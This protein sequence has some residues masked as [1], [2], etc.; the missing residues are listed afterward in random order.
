MTSLRESRRSGAASCVSLSMLCLVGLLGA[1]ACTRAPPAPWRPA[2]AQ[3]WQQLRQELTEQRLARPQQPWS[4]GLRI[5][6]RDPTSGRVI[7]GRGAIAVAPGSAVRMILTG[8]AGATMLDAWVTRVRWRVAV[9]PLSLVRRGDL[10]E[11]REMPVGFLRWWFLT[12]L[13]G[14]LFA[15]TFTDG[16]LLW[17]IRYGGAVID[18]REAA[19]AH[20]RLLHATRRIAGHVE[21][22]EECRAHAAPSVGDS[23]R[24]VDESSG[25]CVDVQLESIASSPPSD[26]AFQD[27]DAPATR[28]PDLPGSGT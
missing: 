13:E 10:A 4:A 9:P 7:D 1:P 8:A 15:A 25:L 11:P 23:A 3:S 21:T 17:L 12:P 22:V 14:S 27:P 18:L 6:M 26:E 2:T 19:C 24:Y 28:Q 16:G 20:G 5:T